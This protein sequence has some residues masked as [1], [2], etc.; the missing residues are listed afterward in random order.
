MRDR[1]DSQDAASQIF[2]KL[3][4]ELKKHEVDNFKSWLHVLTK[5]YCLM[6]LRAR[7][8]DPTEK[9][10]SI[11]PDFMEFSIAVHHEDNHEDDIDTKALNSCMQKLSLEQKKCVS[12]FYLE[13]MSYRQVVEKSGYELKK[14]KS[15]IQNGKRNLRQCLETNAN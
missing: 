5:N 3:I 11:S 10:E 4:V 2:E 7:N 15:Y 14:V 8:A 9:S 12:L 13:E 1:E 6:V